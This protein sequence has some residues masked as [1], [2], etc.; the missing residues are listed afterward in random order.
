MFNGDKALNIFT[1]AN[2]K[3][4]IAYLFNFKEYIDEFR[5]SDN[6]I[7]QSFYQI[8]GTITVV[9]SIFYILIN[10]LMKELK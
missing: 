3:L 6:N 5:I 2:N 4:L 9:Y 8:G 1:K 10:L 7:I